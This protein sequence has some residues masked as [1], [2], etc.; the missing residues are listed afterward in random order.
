M[1]TIAILFFALI[2]FTIRTN[3]QIPNNG[4]EIWTTVGSYGEPTG[5]SSTNIFSTG[6]FYAVTK[7]TDHFPVALGN[8][9][10]RIENN[11]SHLDSSY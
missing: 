4:F 11:T 8:Y 3:A 5:W 2:A 6:P 1:R 9:S 7:S 10:A